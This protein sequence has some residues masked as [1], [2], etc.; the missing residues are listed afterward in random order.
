MYFR[1]GGRDTVGPS[2]FFVSGVFSSDVTTCRNRV[3]SSTHTLFP[4]LDT[5]SSSLRTGR[6]KDVRSTYIRS[7][8]GVF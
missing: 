4:K 7:W 2:P 6:W 3:T 8:L 5:D 1:L